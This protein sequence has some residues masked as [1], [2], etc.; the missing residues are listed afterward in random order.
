MAEAAYAEGGPTQ[1]RAMRCSR[2]FS[3]QRQRADWATVELRPK[4]CLLIDP[5]N[6][7]VTLAIAEAVAQAGSK[8]RAMAL[9]DAYRAEVKFVDAAIAMP[10]SLLR[11]GIQSEPS[12]Q[13]ASAG[14]ITYAG[15]G[16]EIA[17][18][19][20]DGNGHYWVKLS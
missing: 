17:H 12:G 14:R 11:R 16:D 15:R 19:H 10:A 5:L 1:G 20:R 8:D 4:Q 2:P 18:V 3:A 9:L 13:P 6:E 7:R